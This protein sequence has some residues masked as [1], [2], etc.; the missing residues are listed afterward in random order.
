LDWKI[1]I[2]VSIATASPLPLARQA[3]SKA[4]GVRGV[5]SAKKRSGSIWRQLVG[6]LVMKQKLR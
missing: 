3:N 6:K 4:C 5:F 2:K 1:D